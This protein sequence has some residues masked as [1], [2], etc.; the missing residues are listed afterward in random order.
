MP[1]INKN[2]KESQYIKG[3]AKKSGNSCHVVLPRNW[4]G[5]KVLVIKL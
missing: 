2:V 3:K 5:K 1:N 4:E